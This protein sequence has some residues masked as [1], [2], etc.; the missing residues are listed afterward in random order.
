MSNLDVVLVMVH[1]WHDMPDLEEIKWA[2]YS[3]KCAIGAN[4]SPWPKIWQFDYLNTDWYKQHLNRVDLPE[5]NKHLQIAQDGLIPHHNILLGSNDWVTTSNQ[6]TKLVIKYLNPR[7]VLFGGLHKDL[8]VRGV[9]LDIKD[10]Q[11]EYL[12]SDI[13]SYTWK[14]TLKKVEDYNPAF[15]GNI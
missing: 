14:D 4:L 11:R 3:K 6:Q 13:L 7:I 5:W 2:E 15:K 12:E 8:C 10:A 1:V 9:V